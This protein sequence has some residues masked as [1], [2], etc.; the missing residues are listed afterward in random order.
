MSVRTYDLPTTA[1]DMALLMGAVA[2]GKGVGAESRRE[3]LALLLQESF[4]DGIPS[5]VPP[6]SAVAHKSGNFTDATH[7]VALVWG[8][9][10]P[11]VIAVLSDR[12]WDSEPIR[13]V[14]QAVWDY[15]AAHP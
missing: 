5:G 13:A 11:Y 15:F 3:M 1:G 2:A 10:G 7:D 9:G 6:N 12:S 14:S 8:P 4:R